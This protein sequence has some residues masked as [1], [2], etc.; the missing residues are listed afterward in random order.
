MNTELI[1]NAISAFK[2][3]V[4]AC[5]NDVCNNNENGEYVV[6]NGQIAADNQGNIKT[7]AL[8]NTADAEAEEPRKVL[9][10]QFPLRPILDNFADFASSMVDLYK[11][12]KEESEAKAEAEAKAQEEA[13]KA[14]NQEIENKIEDLQSEISSLKLQKKSVRRYKRSF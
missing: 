2:G 1:K 4:A 14:E 9:V 8:V 11:A 3:F 12:D 13:D 10:A 6:F 7:Y 5:G